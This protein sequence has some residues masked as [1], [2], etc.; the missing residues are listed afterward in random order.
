MAD[1]L[2]ESE[3]KKELKKHDK[4]SA[5][6]LSELLR[7]IDKCAARKDHAG[8]LKALD[9]LRDKV[10]KLRAKQS[11]NKELCKYLDAMLAA[12]KDAEKQVE[13]RLEDDDSE[14][15]EGAKLGELLLAVLPR[16]RRLKVEA[17]WH[18]VV[19]QGKPPGLFISRTAISPAHVQRAKDARTG[20]GAILKG[21][22]YGE[23]GIT[24]F[25][26]LEQVPPPGL[27][28]RLKE[29]IKA[30]TGLNVKLVVR[31]GGA[32]IDDELDEDDPGVSNPQPLYGEQ[33]N[34]EQAYRQLLQEVAPL[35]NAALVAPDAPADA[36]RQAFTEAGRL[37]G[38]R[39]FGDALAPLREVLESARDALAAATRHVTDWAQPQA[40]ELSQL[41]AAGSPHLAELT[42]LM[43]AA[44]EHARGRR[45]SEA[46]TAME[47]FDALLIRA[48]TE[49]RAPELSRASQGHADERQRQ[50]FSDWANGLAPELLRLKNGSHPDIET[51]AAAVKQALE[52]SAKGDFETAARLMDGAND[53]LLAALTDQRS[54][55]VRQST[56]QA[57]SEQTAFFTEWAK[58]TTASLTELKLGGA[59]GLAE[60]GELIKATLEAARQHRWDDAVQAM[61]DADALIAEA[62][63]T[64]SASRVLADL[65]QP[66]DE[67][68]RLYR[69]RRQALEERLQRARTDPAIQGPAKALFDGIDEAVAQGQF[70]VALNQL[71]Q[72]VALCQERGSTLRQTLAEL[73]DSADPNVWPLSMDKDADRWRND[74]TRLLKDW[75]LGTAAAELAKFRE[76]I[77]VAK[78]ALPVDFTE[79]RDLRDLETRHRNAGLQN[80][81]FAR[82][83]EQSRSA[84][85]RIVREDGTL[86]IDQ[87]PEL[88]RDLPF[89]RSDESLGAVLEDMGESGVDHLPP[90]KHTRRMLERLR[91]EPELR[92]ALMAIRAPAPESPASDMIRATLG[93]PNDAVL[94]DAHAR[95]AATAALLSQLRQSDAGSCFATSV[96]IGAQTRNPARFLQ[97]LQSLFSSGK[98]TRT[99]NGK[100]VEARLN[101]DMST[102]DL[103]KVQPVRREASGLDKTPAFM[104]VLH[105]LGLPPKEHAG[106][107]DRALAELLGGAD[108]GDLAPQT[109]IAT[110]VKQQKAAR[111][112]GDEDA[113]KLDNAARTAFQGQQDN[114]LLRAWEYTVASLVE[115]DS[116]SQSRTQTL[117]ATASSDLTSQLLTS[118]NATLTSGGSGGANAQQVFNA[119]RGE[120]SRL[121]GTRLKA[122]YDASTKTAPA[123]DGSSS[124]GVWAL[125]DS[126]TGTKLGDPASYKKSLD[127]IARQ[128]LAVFPSDPER[129]LAQR[130]VDRLVADLAPAKAP[131]GGGGHG[132][133]DMISVFYGHDTAIEVEDITNP[134]PDQLMTWVIG[135]SDAMHKSHGKDFSEQPESSGTLMRNSI[136]AFNFRPGTAGLRDMAGEGDATP[137]EKAE[138]F[139]KDEKARNRV[140]RAVS[141]PL[142]DP[143]DGPVQQ[144]VDDAISW[145]NSTTR[146]SVRATIQNKLRALG[147]REVS[148]GWL[149]KV[150]EAAVD[151]TEPTHANVAKRKKKAMG[152]LSRSVMARV[153]PP[154]PASEVDG[155]LDEVLGA[156]KVP[157]D[158]LAEGKKKAL[159]RLPKG[160]DAG[161]SVL[162]DAVDA[163][164]NEQGVPRSDDNSGH[165]IFEA[166]KPKPSLKG[167][168][169]ADT[170]WGDGDHVTMMTWILNPVTDEVEL[171]AMNEDGSGAHQLEHDDWIKGTNWSVP[172]D[173]SQVGGVRG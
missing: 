26:L 72:L 35:L 168:V 94:T 156:L 115:D 56:A 82:N 70:V 142:N 76:A 49:A 11:S 134:T 128:A 57:F 80:A 5:T 103:E 116:R 90:S 120:M 20:S 81:A 33:A 1:Y 9:E 65:D 109:I 46:V 85:L 166:L 41:K 157:Q 60:I 74:I 73:Y 28:K 144:I 6:G 129:A 106:A 138:Q 123:P 59:P 150:I 113:K 164:L 148:A 68:E 111:Q 58:G 160:K 87:L 92:E 151:E 125:L 14:V 42:R 104:A 121:V 95:R 167:L 63:R 107:I 67:A 126:E 97:D 171:W 84:A 36:L 158:Q 98:I 162:K 64:L 91:D 18:F 119:L 163:A 165:R 117:R 161:M 45:W 71:N 159:A 30:L 130:F 54:D 12:I 143:I 50:L 7:D 24:V 110:L 48:R 83:T 89:S 108:Q 29:A 145:Y 99:L 21:D 34:Q 69:T 44:L 127:A 170:N 133:R 43:Q 140:L 66:R 139:K 51:I 105:A 79:M 10:G 146:A 16:V 22:C 15:D 149:A 27:G 2:S 153:A 169:F 75:D 124:R 118:A 53:K 173:P 122:V 100:P 93:L 3:W 96:A 32:Q 86:S 101:L 155:R 135:R 154:V 141:L 17:P 136:H 13:K 112:L 132:S 47:D 52:Q 62:L 172:K 19:A 152:N 77:Q 23:E 147:K 137:Q 114:R 40:L 102:T 88:M 55:E 78:R 131:Q 31:G 61:Q 4:L 8:Q 37:A 25:D 38:E 39:R